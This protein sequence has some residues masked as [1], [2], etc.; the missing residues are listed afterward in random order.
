[1]TI[2]TSISKLIES[3]ATEAYRKHAGEH[4]PNIYTP[5]GSTR[6]TKERAYAQMLEANPE[7]YAAYRKQHNAAPVLAQLSALG[8][9]VAQ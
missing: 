7:A 2:Q 8:L 4:T 5:V 9:R 1:M 6:L 3:R